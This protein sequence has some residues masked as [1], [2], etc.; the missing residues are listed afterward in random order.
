MMIQESFRLWAK[1]VNQRGGI[2]GR[3]VKMVLY[4][5]KSQPSLVKHYYQKLIEEDNVDLVFSPYGTPLTLAASEISE[6]HKYIMLA[7]A[8]AGKSIWQKGYH[9]VFG[10]Y[11][12]A[13]RMFIGLLDMMAGKGHKTLSLIYDATSSFNLDV[14]AGAQ[15][16]NRLVTATE[17][18][19]EGKLFKVD[20]ITDN[21][22]GRLMT[23]FNAMVASLEN[24]KAE[25][26]HLLSR[27]HSPTPYRC[28]HAGNERPG[29]VRPDR[30]SVSADES[31]LHLRL[32]S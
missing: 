21:E 26:R 23:A 30:R 7:C 27:Y 5:D 3:K 2:L 12:P 11:A 25:A 22:L 4:D 18:I 9:Y 1:Q 24:E 6:R 17:G 8:A 10:M 14:V 28:H 15:Q 31:D 32:H 29:I 13:D 20:K 16:F 19:S